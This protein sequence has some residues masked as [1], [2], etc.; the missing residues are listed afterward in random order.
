MLPARVRCDADL[1]ESIGALDECCHRR[2]EGIVSRGA[3]WVE[4]LAPE[5]EPSPRIRSLG[6]LVSVLRDEHKRVESED[7]RMLHP[8]VDRRSKVLEISELLLTQ[9]CRVDWSG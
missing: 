2:C 9:G 7:D 3:E 4:R 8:E 6:K 5:S 1:E